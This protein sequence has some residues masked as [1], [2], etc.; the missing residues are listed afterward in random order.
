M[1]FLLTVKRSKV[2]VLAARRLRAGQE[3][4]VA[5]C[6]MA[7]FWVT[8]ISA[9]AKDGLVSWALRSIS[10]TQLMQ[11]GEWIAG[12]AASVWC[13]SPQEEQRCAAVHLIDECPYFRH[14]KHC[15]SFLTDFS[16]TLRT[17][18]KFS[19][20]LMALLASSGSQRW[21]MR[22]EKAFPASMECLLAHLIDSREFRMPSFTETSSSTSSGLLG[23]KAVGIP[24]AMMG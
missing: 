24:W 16:T 4:A 8:D 3:D 21:M 14:L 23:S 1:F 6:A 13:S 15:P 22:D 10:V 12:Q 7:V 17:E 19:R 20:F 18:K 11:D 9:K 2:F 5:G